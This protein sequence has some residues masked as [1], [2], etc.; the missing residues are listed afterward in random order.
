V[1]GATPIMVTVGAPRRV[2]LTAGILGIVGIVVAA[3]AGAWLV[4]VLFFA[5]LGLGALHNILTAKSIHR[6]TAGGAEPDRKRF[7]FASLGRIT[8]IT[9]LGVLGLVVF[10]KPGLAV[11]VGLL[12]FHFMALIGTSLPLLKELRQ[13]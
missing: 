6:H 3:I 10:H 5:G 9:V 8:Y 4:G 1:D 11:F 7:A 12:I 13:L 2:F